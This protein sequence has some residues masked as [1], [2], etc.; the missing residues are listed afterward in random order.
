M[1]ET[2]V[3]QWRTLDE[4]TAREVH[5]LLK[6][7]QDVFVVEQACAFGEI[8]GR[9]PQALHL[10]V[11]DPAQTETQNNGNG[12]LVGTVRL[13]P[14][15]ESDPASIGRVVIAP[16]QRR[17]GLGRKIMQE[18]I[19]KAR[20]TAPHCLIEVSAQA[21]LEKFYGSLGFTTVSEMYLEDDIP[22]IDMRLS[23]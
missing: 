22:H 4:M 11:F 12:T 2:L 20:G 1:T 6:L 18:G 7:R 15:T 5:D 21:H 16:S 17:T 8:D 10:L 19:K 23:A 14:A 9:D 13:F 3:W